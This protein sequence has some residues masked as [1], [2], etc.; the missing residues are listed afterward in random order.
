MKKKLQSLPG[1]HN[2]IIVI[3]AHT[4]GWG[5]AKAGRGGGEKTP[6]GASHKDGQ[7]QAENRGCDISKGAFLML[8]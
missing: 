8:S 7:D 4:G 2:N 1:A 5:C 6:Q 3:G